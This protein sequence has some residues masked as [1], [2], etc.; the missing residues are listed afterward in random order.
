[1]NEFAPLGAFVAEIGQSYFLWSTFGLQ[2]LPKELPGKHQIFYLAR[3][4][5]SA[6]DAKARPPL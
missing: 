3:R 4:Q 5:G 1:M 6:A 2:L